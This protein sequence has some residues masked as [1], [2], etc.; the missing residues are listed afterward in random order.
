M[1][2]LANS[3]EDVSAEEFKALGQSWLDR[4]HDDERLNWN[5]TPS[6]VH[7]MVKHGHEFISAYPTPPGYW[8]EE[9][10]EHSHKVEKHRRQHH[11][12]KM[13]MDSNL[14]D[15]VVL[16]NCSADPEIS[17]FLQK[18]FLPRRAKHKKDLPSK[19][20]TD[21]EVEIEPKNEDEYEDEYEDE[22]Y[23][24]DCE[25]DKEYEAEFEYDC[26]YDYECDSIVE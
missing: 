4:F 3:T 22:I 11:A 2:N 19:D 20:Q 18:S 24:S 7:G 26:E 14:V 9:G 12:R 10:A 5:W 16:Q 15:I 21:P 17:G 8:T 13:C 6:S 1:T 25:S 23:L